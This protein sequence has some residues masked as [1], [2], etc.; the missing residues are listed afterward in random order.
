MHKPRDMFQSVVVDIALVLVYGSQ[1]THRSSQRFTF[2]GLTAKGIDARA[3]FLLL[4]LVLI[5]TGGVG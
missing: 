1:M 4:V 3:T 2:S 5:T